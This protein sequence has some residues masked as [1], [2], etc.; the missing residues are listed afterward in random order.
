[1]FANEYLQ[2]NLVFQHIC[3][4]THP[5]A[6]YRRDTCFDAHLFRRLFCLCHVCA[7]SNDVTACCSFFVNNMVLH[8]QEK[9]ME[10]KRLQNLK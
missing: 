1:M 9:Q 2:R 4:F 6:V 8:C 7:S 5:A 3:Y 10:S